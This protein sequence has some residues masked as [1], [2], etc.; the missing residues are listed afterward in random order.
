MLFLRASQILTCFRFHLQHHSI[1]GFCELIILTN[2][3]SKKKRL[4]NFEDPL[5]CPVE[6]LRSH[7]LDEYMSPF[8][9]KFTEKYL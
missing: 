6:A 5:L 7:E 2:I 8:T 3:V 1:L 4:P 9:L